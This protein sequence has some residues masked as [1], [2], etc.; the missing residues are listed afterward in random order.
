MPNFLLSRRH[1]VAAAG[2]SESPG[3]PAGAP[4]SSGSGSSP[5]RG[6]RPA[7]LFPLRGEISPTVRATALVLGVG[8]VVGLW[9]LAST[10]WASDTFPV[11]TIPATW[12]AVA[13]M[14]NDGE[15]WPDFVAS[16]QRVVIGYM[17][18][19]VAGV[20]VGLAIGSFTT[21]DAFF[22]PQI[23]FLRYI[24]ATALTPLFMIWFGIDETP[25][26]AL[27]VVGTVFFNILMVADVARQVPSELIRASY[28]LGASRWTVMRRVVF[29]HAW[30]GI[31]DVARVNLAAAWAML[32]V[33]ELLAAQEGL[34]FRIV[35]AQRFRRVDRMFALLL[36]FGVLGIASDMALRTLR[37]RTARWSRDV[38]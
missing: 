27:V 3:A 10:V 15:L 23:G 14:W 25:K 34:A 9:T 29:P 2:P 5:R 12:S 24:P 31:V 1:A 20:V 22:E 11:P 36:V 32:V 35:R 6:R 18:S 38:S 4:T 33:A 26:V 19:I 30:P 28:T 16:L 13:Q 17:L 21:V 8:A 37:N 7:R